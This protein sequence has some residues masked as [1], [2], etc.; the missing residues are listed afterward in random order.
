MCHNWFHGSCVNITVQMSKKISEWFCPEC[1][2][3]KD[4]EVLYCVCKKPYDDQQLV[5]FI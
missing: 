4:P 3:S 5:L 2:R 1:K